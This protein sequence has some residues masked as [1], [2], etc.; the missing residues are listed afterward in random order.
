MKLGQQIPAQTAQAPL[1]KPASPPVLPSLMPAQAAKLQEIKIRAGWIPPSQAIALAKG[2]ATTKTIDAVATMN[3]K[4]IID[5]QGSEDDGNWLDRNVY[6][7]LKATTRWGFAGLNFVPEFVQGGVAQFSKPGDTLFQDGWFNQTTFGSMLQNPELQGEGFFAGQDL[8]NKQAERARKYRGTIDGSAWTVG[9]GAANLVFKPKS[10]P[11]NIMSG[12]LDAL[13]TIKFDP[14]GVATKGAKLATKGG[15]VLGGIDEATG[16]AKVIGRADTTVGGAKLLES[17]LVPRL[18]ATQTAAIRQELADG[19]GLTKGLAE[20]GLDG[21]K[22]A[23]FSQ[24]NRRFSTLVDRI[25]EEK[26]ATRI[27]ED[28]FDHK[29]PNE[30]VSALAD[31][32]DPDVVRA[33]LATG[34][35]IGGQALPQDI[36]N[37]QKTLLGSRTI[38]GTAIGDIMHERMPLIEGL[39]K[40]RYFTKMAKGSIVTSG[41]SDDNR[42]AVRSVISYLRTAGVDAEEVDSVANMVIRGFQPG[43]SDVA[44]K[45]SLDVFEATMRSVMKRDGITD[46]VIDELFGRARG[47]VE[48]VRKYLADRDGLPTD[49]GYSAHILNKNQNYLPDEE[50]ETLLSEIGYRQ[51]DKYA[52]TSPTEISEMLD[53]IQVLPDLRDVRRITRNKLFREVLD[54]GVLPGKLPLTG[55]RAYRLVTTITDQKEFDRLGSEI[56]R[57]KGIPN[58][59]QDT[60]D[61][62]DD[63][64]GKQNVL[65]IKERKKVVTAEQRGAIEAIDY[66]QNKLWKPL[67]LATGGYIVRNSL[68]AQVRM[69]FSELPSLFTHPYEYIN[70]VLGTSNKMSLKLENL[71]RLGTVVDEKTLLKLNKDV[72]DLQQIAVRTPKEERRLQKLLQKQTELQQSADNIQNEALEDLAEQLGFGLRQQG[73]GADGIE[74]HMRKTGTFTNVSRADSNG[75]EMHTD[76]VAQNGYR[77]HN[78]ALRKIATQTFVS[79]G[80]VTEISRQQAARKIVNTILKNKKLRKQ[81]YDLHEYGFEVTNARTG[82]KS[83]TAPVRLADLPEDEVKT[84]LL[85]YAYRIPVDNAQILTGNL[86]EVTFMYA[87]NRVPRTVKGRIV[88]EFES[89]VDEL[90]NL[91]DGPLRVGTIVQID[92]DQV[93]VVTRLKDSATRET[94][95]DVDSDELVE[96]LNYKPNDIAI[97]QPI[98]NG[99]AFGSSGNGSRDA[100]RLIQKQQLW[101]EKSGQGLPPVLKRELSKTDPKDATQNS[102]FQDSYDDG[103]EWFFSDVYGTVTRKLERSPVFREYYYQEVNALVDR[104]SPENVQKFLDSVT[105]AAKK[106][107]TTPEKYVGNKELIARMKNVINKSKDLPIRINPSLVKQEGVLFHGTPQ[108]LS[109]GQFADVFSVVAPD[110]NNLFGRGVYLT[111]SPDVGV[112]YT[113]KGAK[114]KKSIVDGK[115]VNKDGFVYKVEITK[116]DNFIDLR[117]PSPK[118]NEIL[119]SQLSDESIAFL[120]QYSPSYTDESLQRFI[121]LLNDENASGETVFS[122]FKRL[123]A[124]METGEVDSVIQEVTLALRDVADGLIYQGGVRKG[125]LGEHTAYVVLNENAVRVVEELSPV[126]KSVI[127]GNDVSI[128]ELDEFAKV[129]AVTRMKE[130]LYDASERSNLQDALR[131]IMPFAPAWKEVLGTYAGFFKSNPIGSARQFQRIYTGIGNADPDNDGRGFF[132]KDPT[133]NKLMFTFPGSGTLAK[134]LTGL[135]ATLEAPVSRLSQGI[136]AFPAL[137]PMAQIAA[138][139]IIPDVPE[140]DFMVGVLLPY[141]RK[142]VDALVPGS[143]LQKFAAAAIANEDDVTGIYA[144]TYIETMRALSATGEYDLSS[145]QEVEQ[146]QRDAKFKARILTAFRALSQF[147]GPTAGTTEFKVP[148][149]EGDQFMSA[150][151]KEFYDMQADPTIGYDKALPQFL[152]KYG[153]EMALYVSSKSRTTV[154]GLEATAEFGDWERDNK[155]LIKAYPDV[156]RYLAPAGSDFNF[157]VWDRQR[158]SGERV[159]LTDNELIELAQNRIGSAKFRYAREQVGPYPSAENK[160]LLKRYRTYL[161]SQYPGFPAVAEFEVGKYYNDVSDLK[162]LVFDERVVGDVTAEAIKKYL[163]EREQAIVA[164]GVSEQGFRS[165]KAA[166]PFR[167]QLASIGLALSKRE[168]NFARIFDRLLA[169]EVE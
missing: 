70:L 45:Q 169:S 116:K 82:L 23:A 56:K 89:T 88:P 104:L 152:A 78:D 105:E 25:V 99:D 43:S 41:T 168:P 153:D 66:V 127:A 160:E 5:E 140:T 128:D 156:A 129:Q 59:T 10:L 138:S 114:N 167:D 159:T 148:T 162:K 132:Y 124:G 101:D 1:N 125:G 47:G 155:G 48:R 22:Y 90:A 3:A 19:V 135:D 13:V 109:G 96:R 133:T 52:I 51:G 72:G 27:A 71:S 166:E 142:S 58:K 94:L 121:S 118:L 165:A 134:A 119:W 92:D 151:V 67:A 40:S 50:I 106:A 28:I 154:E 80:G 93:G 100:R 139:K 39:R 29:L 8:M 84:V 18:S 131:I 37:L 86:P 17:S 33:I 77:S 26:S 11:Y 21:T 130:L 145:K 55:K 46:E 146:L 108:A 16:A 102:S 136:Q 9:R 141:G 83:R 144:N 110:A 91:G 24:S 38:M 12:V 60:F 158:R 107:K 6:D 122:S 42:N 44:R 137:G 73:I 34:W 126:S 68:D 113:A 7:R 157:T 117:K 31:A 2:N 35:D 163:L 36:R 62:I 111:D 49:N 150:L 69:A 54:S 76:A 57:L 15:V 97:V 75:L 32:N 20:Y 147:A 103:V 53:R 115:P 120:E 4:R 74:E 98:E 123:F 61:E 143:Y 30:I 63:L 164:S 81:I 65:K 161:S 112:S 149:D 95:V 64:V 87:F 85:Q 14:T 79:Y